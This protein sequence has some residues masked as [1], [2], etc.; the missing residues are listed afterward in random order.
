MT[1]RPFI[2]VALLAALIA[3]PAGYLMAKDQVGTARSAGDGGAV[4]STDGLTV[5][6]MRDLGLSEGAIER[7]LSWREDRATMDRLEAEDAASL[8]VIPEPMPAET[9]EWCRKVPAPVESEMTDLARQCAAILLA[10]E[11][12]LEGGTYT[13]EA[14]SAAIQRAEA[15]G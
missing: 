4:G 13:D 6:K 12:K 7:V 15:A 3:A 9:A 5:E 2:F 14:L 11:G 10:A 1:I 8:N